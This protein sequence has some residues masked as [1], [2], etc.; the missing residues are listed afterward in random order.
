MKSSDDELRLRRFLDSLR[1][2]HRN[3]RDVESVLRATLRRAAAFLDA[4]AG[5]VARLSA[6]DVR[7]E[8][9]FE[10]GS[11]LAWDVELLAGF[12]RNDR[13]P[14]RSDIAL[15]PVERRQRPRWRAL[16]LRRERAFEPFERSAL[17][18]IA[19]E[20]SQ[21]IERMDRQRTADVRARIDGKILAELRP[22]DLFYQILHG[23]RTLTRYD[24]SA[25]L[26]IAGE[27]HDSLTL[28]AEQIAWRKGKSLSIGRRLVLTPKLISL[29]QSGEVFGFDRSRN[30]P[31]NW[32]TWSGQSAPEL[33]E[34][35]DYGAPEDVPEGVMI[36]APVVSQDGVIGVLKV[37]SVHSGSLGAYEVELVRGFLPQVSVAIQNSRRTESL[38]A[39]MVEAEKKHAMANLARSVAH[40]VNN[41][42]G[43]I[44]PLVQQLRREVDSG[45]VDLEELAEDLESIDSSLQV[46]RRI[47]GGML[48]YARGAAR[49]VG[50]ASLARSLRSALSI[51]ERTMQRRGVEL[52][53]DVPPDFE[54]LVPIACRQSELEQLLFNL[55]SNACHAMPTGGELTVQVE[56]RPES[57][58]LPVVVV[59]S[60]TGCG[61]PAATLGRVHE[62]FFTTK[63]AGN[64]LGLT[65]CRSI[66]WEIGGRMEIESEEGKGTR[67]RLQLP[68]IDFTED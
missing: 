51:L 31:G 28:V 16:A 60:D 47:F 56:H 59:I 21:Q 68:T 11:A 3:S 13:P 36:C 30:E 58:E 43:S 25:A 23:L 45:E 32:V 37:A 24:H 46:C 48:S 19:R 1:S 14:V 55:L 20:L 65:I 22:K 18:Q 67:V 54:E 27:A 52:R 29:I 10:F 17:S 39:K 64:G 2:Q 44:L 53:L 49:G 41:A 57:P 4:E 34:L 35:L 62:P 66:L 40:D 15:A 26:L 38:Q 6:G 61:I 7:S 9:V 42:L 12:L 8:V 50:E 5:C 63:P 33:A